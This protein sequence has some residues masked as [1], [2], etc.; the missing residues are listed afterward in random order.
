MKRKLTYMLLIILALAIQ[1]SLLPGSVFLQTGGK[2]EPEHLPEVSAETEERFRE[3][4]EEGAFRA[5]SF[6]RAIRPI[7]G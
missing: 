7:R 4:Y 3:I 1:G 2:S 6:P 5:M